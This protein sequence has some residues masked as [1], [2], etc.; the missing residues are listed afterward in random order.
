MTV[1]RLSCEDWIPSL[2][3]IAKQ[4]RN[5]WLS[6]DYPAN[7]KES[8][9]QESIK[10]PNTFHSKISKGKKDALKVTASQS[11]HYKQKAK[12]TVSSKGQ[13]LQKKM[14][15]RL[16]KIKNFTKTYMQ[17]HTLTDVVN[18]SWSTALERS[19]KLLLRALNQFYVATT[20]ALS[21]AMVYTRYLFS[22]VKDSKL[23]SATPPGT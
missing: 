1:H 15:K 22:C 11:K 17:R 14:A 6:T 21:S 9:D 12:R 18:H 19:V 13:F 3:Q 2:P 8:N 23:I 4:R 20:L 7:R 10:L 5:T 16:S